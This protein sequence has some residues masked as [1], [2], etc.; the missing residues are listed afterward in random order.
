MLASV[1]LRSR[2]GAQFEEKTDT[3]KGE[4]AL[5]YWL[6]CGRE[7]ARNRDKRA[8]L[9]E[10][11]WS[12]SPPRFG[13]GDLN[14]LGDGVGREVLFVTMDGMGPR[15]LAAPPGEKR[16]G[17]VPARARLVGCG[18]LS[19]VGRCVK[20]GKPSVGDSGMFSRRGVELPLVGGP[21][22]LTGRPSWAWISRALLQI[23]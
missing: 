14:G 17:T 3:P 10:L 2:P 15:P 5:L 18:R 12:A 6:R 7:P 22:T 8:A 21:Q 11:A 20:S 16:D 13:D 19:G 1:E 4:V 9:W 23:C